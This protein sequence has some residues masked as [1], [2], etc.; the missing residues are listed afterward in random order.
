MIFTIISLGV[1][2]IYLTG[3][4][5]Y[6]T[7]KCIYNLVT[8]ETTEKTETTESILIKRIDNLEKKI[9]ELKNLQ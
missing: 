2:T 4:I 3:K 1:D 5:T 6:Y 7:G 8:T 9:E